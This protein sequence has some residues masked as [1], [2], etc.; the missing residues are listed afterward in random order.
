MAGTMWQLLDHDGP[1]LASAVYRRL[2]CDLEKG[3][4]RLKRAAAAVRFAA[5]NLEDGDVDPR[6]GNLMIGPSIVMISTV[7]TSC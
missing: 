2:M 6:T 4:T 7:R 3:Q 5:L 1:F